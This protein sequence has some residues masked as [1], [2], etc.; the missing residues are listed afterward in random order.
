[1]T[2]PAPEAV[3]EIRLW[4]DGPPTAI[5]GVGPEVAYAAA[6]GVAGGT[7][8]LRNISDP[9][10]KVF[11]PPVE[12]RHDIGVVVVPGGGWTINAMSHEGIEVARW[13]TQA[14]YTVF[15]LKYRV[16]AS[17]PDQDKFE[18]R[19]ARSDR[20][21]A[22]F[23]TAAN[24]P[25]EIGQLIDTKEYHEAR[26]AAADD[27]RRA[28]ELVRE[29]AS[30]YSLRPEGIGMIGF[31]A[32][33]FL[34][35][36]VALD[37]R[38]PSPAFLGAIYGGET[39]GAAVPADAPPLF[40]VVA[41]DDRLLFRIVE[42]LYGDWSNAD[43]PSELHVF[44]RGGHGFGMVRQGLPVDRWTDLFLDWLGHLDTIR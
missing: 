34:I 39:R 28:L 29:A 42:G 17:S 16:M 43:R 40:A 41:Q 35:V 15:L 3:E 38:G 11:V 44:A 36:D 9:S 13:L 12:H 37:G 31:S 7:T 14:G 4:P 32:G 30:R 26:N 5:E 33:A 22:S 2:A 21:L 24:A 27:G 19:M 6:G 18:A 1:M 25:R 8:F 10:I 20:T 23:T